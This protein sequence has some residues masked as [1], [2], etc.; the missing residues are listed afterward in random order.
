LV[1]FSSLSPYFSFSF[2]GVIF[3]SFSPYSSSHGFFFL[4]L[5]PPFSLLF[6]QIFLLVHLFLFFFGLIYIYIF[7]VFSCCFACHVS[8]LSSYCFFFFFMCWDFQLGTRMGFGKCVC[9]ELWFG[10]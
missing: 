2:V 8:S 5:L 1:I 4:S 7:F 10:A 6:F 3:S 9:L